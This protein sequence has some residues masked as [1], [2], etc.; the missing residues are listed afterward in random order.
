[1]T[2]EEQRNGSLVFQRTTVNKCYE[3]RKH[4]KRKKKV[5]QASGV[6]WWDLK[7]VFMEGATP[8]QPPVR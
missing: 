7:K 4:Y 8:L 6:R 3:G 5:K 2:G 1:M